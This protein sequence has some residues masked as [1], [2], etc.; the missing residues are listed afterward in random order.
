MEAAGVID[1]LVV[2]GAAGDLTF[3]FLLPALAEL[4]RAGHLTG[5]F[6]LVGVGREAWTSAEF[7]QRAIDSLGG[8]EAFTERLR[9]VRADATDSDALADA[10]PCDRS[11]LAYLALPP[12]V[13]AP[14]V[15][16]LAAADL[17]EGSRIVVEKPFGTD[18]ASAIRLNEL[19]HEVFDERDIFRVDHFLG[20]QTVQNVLGLRF[21][22]RVFEALWNRDHVQR[23]EITWD[24]T[25][26]LEGRA[27][28]Y[29]QTGAL[30][31]MVQN[32][33]LQLLCLVA[34]EPPASLSAEDLRDRKVEV[35]RAIRTLQR[36][37]V[38]RI[39]LRARYAGYTDEEGVDPQRGTETFAQVTLFVDSDRWAGVPFVLRTGKALARDRHE[40]AVRFKPVPTLVFGQEEQPRPNILRLEVDPDRVALGLDLNGNGDP[41]TLDHVE[42]DHTLAPAQ[43]GAY[44]RVLLAALNGDPTLSIRADEAEL[45]WR[46][47]EP[48]LAA[49]RGGDPPLREYLAG[50]GG[51][52]PP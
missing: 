45:S 50:S 20:L 31:D 48:I 32:H 17:P 6:E 46:I 40:I 41:F 28:Y 34:L 3:R 43:L 7:R 4:K 35:L 38:K 14:A 19:L 15:E 11:T 16:A 47:V 21:A 29:D 13:F 10:F 49:W 36:D 22:N 9:W 18:L 23:V 12:A 1:C 37:Q 2:L 44:A 5:D 25:L 24:E 52:Q 8:D 26:A 33:L 42:L 51:P 39:T 27:G 30:E